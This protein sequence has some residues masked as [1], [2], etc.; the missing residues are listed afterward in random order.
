MV[1]WADA[2]LGVAL[3]RTLN[4]ALAE[5]HARFPERLVGLAT[6]PMQD[7]PAAVAELERAAALPG[8]RGVY[9]GTNV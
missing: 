9:L 2:A 6:L 5:A 3:A 7:P 4:D 1:Y 8:I